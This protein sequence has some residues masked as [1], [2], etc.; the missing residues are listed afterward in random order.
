LGGLTPILVTYFLDPKRVF[1]IWCQI[2]V[3]CHGR[4]NVKD[5]I[6]GRFSLNEISEAFEYSSTNPDKVVKTIVIND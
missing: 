2:W 4:I 5:L 1:F 6:T 3:Y